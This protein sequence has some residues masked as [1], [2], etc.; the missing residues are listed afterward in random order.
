M[1]PLFGMM[2]AG[3]L[4]VEFTMLSGRATVMFTAYPPLKASS[5]FYLGML[6]EQACGLPAGRHGSP[7]P[8]AG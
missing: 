1:P 4:L 3:A 6:L 2:L 5:W 8:L 7:L